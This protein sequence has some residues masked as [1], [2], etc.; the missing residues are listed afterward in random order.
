MPLTLTEMK[1]VEGWLREYPAGVPK[2]AWMSKVLACAE[3]DNPSA[4]FHN[5]EQCKSYT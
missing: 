4:I 1:L 3:D 2:Y 5:I